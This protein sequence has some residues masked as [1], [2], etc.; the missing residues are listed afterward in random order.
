PR[1]SL[2]AP[3]ANP[4]A[5]ESMPTSSAGK[6]S[7]IGLRPVQVGQALGLPTALPLH[8]V[9]GQALGLPTSLPLH[10]V[11]GQALG[12]PT[13][14]PLHAVVGHA[15]AC[16]SERSSDSPLSALS[17]VSAPHHAVVGQASACQSERSSDSSLSSFSA[18]HPGQRTDPSPQLSPVLR[19]FLRASASPRQ[20]EP[21]APSTT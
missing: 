17:P 11:V 14:L 12:L 6:T 18:P 4:A 13:S 19:V 2:S 21:L 16:Q 3:T 9:V 5:K 8:A 1:S 20:I 7:R 10:A 15:S